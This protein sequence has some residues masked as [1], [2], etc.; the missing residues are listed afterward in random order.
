MEL[1]RLEY[2]ENGAVTEPDV[3]IGHAEGVLRALD[4]AGIRHG[5][6]T[7]ANILV[8]DNHPYVIDF[9][10]SRLTCDPRLDKRREG[11]R[12]WLEKTME[13][14]CNTAGSMS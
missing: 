5:D 10:E 7:D 6:L 13:K 11:D 9:S 14:L 12:Y 8:R 1:I 4:N 2:I 3:L